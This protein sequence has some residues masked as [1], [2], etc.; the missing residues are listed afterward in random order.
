[1]QQHNPAI[2]IYS[3]A[4]DFNDKMFMQLFGANSKRCV[5]DWVWD[6][7]KIISV[8]LDILRRRAGRSYAAHIADKT[9][10]WLES[11]CKARLPHPHHHNYSELLAFLIWHYY[12]LK[13]PMRDIADALGMTLPQLWDVMRR[14]ISTGRRLYPVDCPPPS[15]KSL[16]RKNSRLKNRFRLDAPRIYE[17]RQAGKTFEEIKGILLAKAS[18]VSIANTYYYFCQRTGKTRQ[19]SAAATCANRETVRKTLRASNH[20]AKKTRC[21]R[22]HEL[23]PGNLVL[24]SL[25]G[26]DCLI[27]SRTRAQ[28]KTHKA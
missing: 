15:P 21:P 14:V 16:H 5:P 4:L 12:R 25:P 24:S 6:N 9:R 26:R 2:P 23:K 22:G 27:C 13:W 19:L 1:M 28:A 20:Q 10:D 3:R 8:I 11:K 18:T 17:L 7:K